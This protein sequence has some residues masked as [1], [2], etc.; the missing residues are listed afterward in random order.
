MK[1][2]MK[3]MEHYQVECYTIDSDCSKNC[4]KVVPQE[5]RVFR[6]GWL[7]DLGFK[8]CGSCRLQEKREVWFGEGEKR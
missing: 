5:S 3:N 1:P 8:G 7:D 4:E 6:E 2:F